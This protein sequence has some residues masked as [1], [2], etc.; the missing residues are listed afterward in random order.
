MAIA[1]AQAGVKN[2]SGS[3]TVSTTLVSTPTVGN[4]VVV[5]VGA[6]VAGSV[7]SMTT[8]AT[9]WT[10]I[11][12]RD[13]DASNNVSIFARVVAV[14]ESSTYTAS[15]TSAGTMFLS[16]YEISGAQATVALAVSANNSNSSGATT[17][18]TLSVG[19]ITPTAGKN[20]LSINGIWYQGGTTT[21]QSIDGGFSIIGTGTIRGTSAHLVIASTSG[22][23]NPSYSWTTLRP[24]ATVSCMVVAVASE[25]DYLPLLGVG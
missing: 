12:Q 23:Y 1:L 20:R 18:T 3:A 17:V 4:I 6:N 13:T 22:T 11:V 19:S 24:T 10:T 21:A 8:P 25:V 7:T 9:G 16:V 14:S 5:V 2:T 15:A